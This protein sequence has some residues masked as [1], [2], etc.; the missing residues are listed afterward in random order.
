MVGFQIP[1][2]ISR[3]DALVYERLREIR[4]QPSWRKKGHFGGHITCVTE[5]FL[6]DHLVP[7]LRGEPRFPVHLVANSIDSSADNQ[8]QAVLISVD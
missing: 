4:W 6:R 5:S 3:E 7:I 8:S 2:G 1:A